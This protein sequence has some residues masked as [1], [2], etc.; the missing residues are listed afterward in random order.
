M[1]AHSR[2]AGGL[3]DR[4]CHSSG[5]FEGRGRLRERA[6][7][8][9]MPACVRA[10]VR[11]CIGVGARGLTGVTA[12]AVTPISP[13]RVLACTFAK[14]AC[15]WELTSMDELSALSARVSGWALISASA[16]ARAR[17]VCECACLE[18]CA[19]GRRS[20]FLIPLAPH[21]TARNYALQRPQQPCRDGRRRRRRRAL[22]N[23]GAGAAASGA[24]DRVSSC[25]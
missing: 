25:V 24:E 20:I 11:E 10:C 9:R 14:R 12:R 1:R 15:A 18:A 22:V 6:L 17:S 19:C 3:P 4:V 16:R 8:A 23:G 13:V 21:S 2:W 5:G 7:R